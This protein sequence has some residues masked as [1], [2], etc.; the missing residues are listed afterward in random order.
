MNGAKKNPPIRAL[1]VKYI[2]L[3]FVLNNGGF[4]ALFVLL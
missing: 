4:F 2:V 1:Y 3:P